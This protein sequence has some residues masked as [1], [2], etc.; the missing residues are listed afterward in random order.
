MPETKGH[1]SEKLPDERGD[2][3]ISYKAVLGFTA[4][5]FVLVALSMGL[6][7]GLTK[8]A[9]REIAGTQA[10]PPPLA[11]ARENPLPPEPR[12][13]TAPAKDLAALRER[14]NAVLG[15]YAWV[16]RAKGIAEVPVDRAIEIAAETGLPVKYGPTPA[17]PAVPAGGPSK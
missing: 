16:D 10:P 2:R 4:F 3:E 5:L 12:L 9:K 8:A 17:V 6:M 11:G 15:A 13:E 1:G 14:E 7:W